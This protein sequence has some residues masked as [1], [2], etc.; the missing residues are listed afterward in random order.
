MSKNIIREALHFAKKKHDATQKLYNGE[1]FIFHPILTYQILLQVA[2]GDINL[3]AAGLLHDVLE[4][5]QTSYQELL[6]TFGTDITALVVE[7][8]KTA[9]NTFPALTTRRGVLLKFADRL[10]NLSQ[11]DVK[12]MQWQLEYIEKSRFW[13]T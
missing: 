4:E 3:L 7:V 10:A 9:Y 11:M 1:P 12:D 5:T 2:E 13:K 8:T 6:E